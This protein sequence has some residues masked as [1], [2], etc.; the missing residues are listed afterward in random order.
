MSYGTDYPEALEYD[1]T[2]PEMTIDQAHR[3]F[4]RWLGADY[5]LEALDIV[6]SAAAVERLDGDPV[7]LLLVSGSGNAKTETVGALAGAGAFHVDHHQR[8][9][10]AL[11][12]GQ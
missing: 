2:L 3:V 1:P 12:H 7:W 11:G 5:D 6:L 10:V 8:G 4:A 9:R